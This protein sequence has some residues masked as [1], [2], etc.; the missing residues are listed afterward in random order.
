MGMRGRRTLVWALAFLSLQAGVRGGERKETVVLVHGILNKPFMMKRVESVL[1]KE[2]FEVR[3]W[4][5]PS[6]EKSIEEL[7][8]EVAAFV[9]SLPAAEAVHF[10]GFS[11][12]TQVLRRYLSR[13]P[14]ATSL[15]GL[16]PT[17][18]GSSWS[19]LPTTGRP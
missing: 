9:E 14:P 19:L 4:G 10:V 5:Y 7:S 18:G 8:D 17:R 13:R 2:G 16:P 11:L 12:G 6:T 15:G 3:N 1:E